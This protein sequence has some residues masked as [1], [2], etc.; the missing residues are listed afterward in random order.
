MDPTTRPRDP[1]QPPR[2]PPRHRA[3]RPFRIRS[4]LLISAHGAA[5]LRHVPVKERLHQIVE[6]MSDAEAATTLD[7]LAAAP[8]H[9]QGCST[10]P[11]EDDEPLTD[12]AATTRTDTS[13]SPASSR[14]DATTTD[15]PGTA[16]ASRRACCGGAKAYLSTKP[17][18]RWIQVQ[19]SSGAPGSTKAVA[20]RLRVIA[21]GDGI[22]TRHSGG[23]TPHGIRPLPFSDLDDPVVLRM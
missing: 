13:R 11:P 12:E 1:A 20:N 8:I 14:A 7:R 18:E 9:S 6:E 22:V 5:T 4:A 3:L 2:A 21:H 15:D 10:Q 17:H 23:E 16:H 19:S